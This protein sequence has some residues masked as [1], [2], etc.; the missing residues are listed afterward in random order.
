VRF[1]VLSESATPRFSAMGLGLLA[2]NLVLGAF[3]YNVQQRM[4]QEHAFSSFRSS[5]AVEV[6]GSSERMM[7][8]MYSAGAVLFVLYAA[9]VGELSSF[10][11]WSLHRG[12]NPMKELLPIACSACLTAVG[13]RALLRVTEEF[14]AA[15]ASLITTWR[16]SCTF[17]LSYWLFPKDF[18]WQHCFAVALVVA[19]SAG[20]H[21]ELSRKGRA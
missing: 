11:N 16:K 3:T 13:I 8:V 10:A 12:S 6:L 5:Q 9:V 14:D 7:F 17:I 15:R 2:L 21:R 4:L 18:G 20:V 19:G 1:V